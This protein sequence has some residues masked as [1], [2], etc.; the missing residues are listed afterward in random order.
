MVLTVL[1]PRELQ[2]VP[3]W[4]LLLVVAVLL[5]ALVF[6][7]PGRLDRR[8]KE[9]RV[10]SI[11]L[12]T[13]LVGNALIATYLLIGDL[14]RGGKE[15]NSATALLTAGAVVWTSNNIAFSLLYWELDGGGSAERTHANSWKRCLLR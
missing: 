5:L 8:S 7:D 13:V 2:L 6:G 12:V 4:L 11:G 15:T 10:V 14:I 1:L 9:L 3:A